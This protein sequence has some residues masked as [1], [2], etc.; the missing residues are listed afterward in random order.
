MQL[1]D[2]LVERE[3]IDTE[4]LDLCEHCELCNH[5]FKEV[6]LFVGNLEVPD[7]L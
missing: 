1:L 3:S 6:I 7:E 2:Q 4:V 5:V